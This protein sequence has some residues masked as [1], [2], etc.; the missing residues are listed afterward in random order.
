MSVNGTKCIALIIGSDPDPVKRPGYGSGRKLYFFL[1]G[2]NAN[3]SSLRTLRETSNKKLG[4]DADVK[5]NT[6]RSAGEGRILFGGMFS[7]ETSFMAFCL[8]L[9][10][11]PPSSQC[12]TP[13]RSLSPL[14]DTITVHPSLWPS[15]YTTCSAPTSRSKQI[16]SKW[17][18]NVLKFM[19]LIRTHLTS[20]S[21]YERRTFSCDKRSFLR[22]YCCTQHIVITDKQF[23]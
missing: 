21:T 16:L 4:N 9:H 15:G 7:L 3:S 1:A 19:C 5:K 22:T 20:L 8:L 17:V 2:N 10:K 6:K 13:T 23:S 14:T 11:G 12:P 18:N